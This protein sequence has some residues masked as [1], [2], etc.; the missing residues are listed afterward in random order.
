MKRAGIIGLIF[1]ILYNIS[2]SLCYPEVEI[3]KEKRS[4]F[5][6]DKGELV[7]D[8][9]KETMIQPFLLDSEFSNITALFSCFD[10]LLNLNFNLKSIQLFYIVPNLISGI[11]DVISHSILVSSKYFIPNASLLNLLE[12]LFTLR[13]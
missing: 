13:I 6:K 4:P 10:Y 2:I 3:I 1:L 5:L 7:F 8:I 9:Q 11:Q 12:N